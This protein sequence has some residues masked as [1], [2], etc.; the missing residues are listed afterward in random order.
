MAAM[1]CA[2]EIQHETWSD[3]HERVLRSMGERMLTRARLHERAGARYDRLDTMYALPVIFLSTLASAVSFAS[4]FAPAHLR[5]YS[6]LL[7]GAI[8]TAVSLIQTLRQFAKISESLSGHQLAAAQFALQARHVGT[9]LSVGRGDRMQTGVD[10]IREANQQYDKT[11]KSPQLPLR[12][13]REYVMA[14]RRD[15]EADRELE[16]LGVCLPDELFSLQPLRIINDIEPQE[17]SE[18]GSEGVGSAPP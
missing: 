16:K 4:S 9:V 1:E 17:A 5:D 12:I 14:I 18:R 7:I 8:S 2:T 15:A 13:K 6:A 10:T 3:R 11:E